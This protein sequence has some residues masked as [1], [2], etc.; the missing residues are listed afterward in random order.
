MLLRDAADKTKPQ[1]PAG[2][3][4]TASGAIEPFKQLFQFGLRDDRAGILHFKQ[5][6]P[7]RGCDADQ[8]LRATSAVLNGVARQ[9]E[10]GAGDERLIAVYELV[11]TIQLY[12]HADL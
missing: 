10:Q 5:H 3:G 2:D 8:N 6:V 12:P 9:V 4:L 7:I 11:V 1:A